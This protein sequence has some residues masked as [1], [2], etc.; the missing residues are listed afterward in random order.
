MESDSEVRDAC[1]AALGSAMRVIGEKPMNSL[2]ADIVED[3]LKMTKV[4]LE[5]I[6][7]EIFSEVLFSTKKLSTKTLV[8]KIVFEL[9]RTW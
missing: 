7:W 4:F 8:R 1:Y 6:F 2:I 5:I 9:K 3:K